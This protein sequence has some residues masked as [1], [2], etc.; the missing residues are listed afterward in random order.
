M[1][2][3][4]LTLA[5][6]AALALPA[7]AAPPAPN[8]SIPNPQGLREQEQIRHDKAMRVLKEQKIDASPQRTFDRRSCGND[9]GCI[10][11]VEARYRDKVIAI[12]KKMPEETALHRK[13]LLEIAEMERQ[14]RS[15][16]RLQQQQQ[17]Q[18]QRQTSQPQATNPPG[19]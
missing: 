2:I 17:T 19:N 1:T 9:H 3:P 12:D 10:L 5:L 7:V 14:Y 6:L 11:G 4:P 13:A 15:Y 18:Q 16:G 8:E